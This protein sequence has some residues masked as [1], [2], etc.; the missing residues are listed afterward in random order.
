MGVCEN[1]DI[2]GINL[3]KCARAR[4]RNIRAKVGQVAKVVNIRA[5]VP[6]DR[7]KPGSDSVESA[8][9]AQNFAGSLRS[10]TQNVSHNVHETRHPDL[11]IESRGERSEPTKN[12][13]L[14]AKLGSIKLRK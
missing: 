8:I 3:R 6:P 2:F 4:A 10:P 11:N 13:A 5:K 7:P 9:Q 1:D 14:C 12:F